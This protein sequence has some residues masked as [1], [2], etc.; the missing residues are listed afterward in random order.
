MPKTIIAAISDYYD[1][2]MDEATEMC[3]F[4]K[5]DMEEC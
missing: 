5:E 1:I 3:D 4:D 2:T